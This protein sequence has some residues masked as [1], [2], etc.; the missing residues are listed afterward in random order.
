MSSE[1]A[2]E[3]VQSRV[4]S[5]VQKTLRLAIAQ[6]PKNRDK[7]LT[8]LYNDLSQKIKKKYK[9]ITVILNGYLLTNRELR[10]Q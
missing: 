5:E 2:L 7:L 4:V 10:N 6:S 1:N 9:S 8:S 3:E